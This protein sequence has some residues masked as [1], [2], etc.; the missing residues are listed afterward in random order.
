MEQNSKEAK[1]SQ[2]NLL[3]PGSIIAAGAIIALAVI[4]SGNPVPRQDINLGSAPNSPAN[5]EFI[6]DLADDDPVLGSP[7]APVTVVEFSDFQCP[8]CEKFFQTVEPRLKEEYIKTGKVRFVYRDFPISSIHEYAQKAAE[9][10]ECADE[11]DKFWIYHDRVFTEQANLNFESLK[12]WAA[13]IGLDTAKFNQCLDSGKYASE[14][15][16]DLADGQKAGVAGTP[17]TFINNQFISG[18]VPYE[19]FKAAIDSELAKKTSNE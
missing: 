3:I 10:A 1:L 15:G 5:P 8:F 19:Q 17:G 6:S 16:S 11:Q 4:Y 18:A 14:V 9:A 2:N 12:R 13:D 7:D